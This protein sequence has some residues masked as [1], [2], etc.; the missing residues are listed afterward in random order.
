MNEFIINKDNIGEFYFILKTSSSQIMLTSQSY[1]TV[2]H[3]LQG[4]KYVKINSHLDSQFERKKAS[5]NKFYFILKDSNDQT[6]GMGQKHI[7]LNELNFE[8][9]WVKA[10][11]SIASVREPNSTDKFALLLTQYYRIIFL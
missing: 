2:N 5:D 8:L 7:C 6:I 1:I 4:I 11:A 3:C 10:N 9:N